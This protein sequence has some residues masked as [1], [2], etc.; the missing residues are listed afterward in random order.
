[1]P[2]NQDTYQTFNELQCCVII[3]TYNNAATL[4]KVIE[5]VQLYTSNII[6]I[7]D[8]ST[9][10]TREILDS[11][12]NIK[13]LHLP[14]N[15]GKGYA[16]RKAFQLAHA[17]GYRYGITIDSDGQHMASDLPAFLQKIKEEPDTIIIGARNMQQENVPKKNSFGNKFS[18]FWFRFETGIKL[19]DTQSGY[20]AYPIHLLH[21]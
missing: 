16:L 15:C 2:H 4:K 11:L 9:D 8:G 7:N 10:K 6:V 18:N 12:S 14:K 13:V 17:E 3:P 5:D 20:R 21:K 19:P 1:M